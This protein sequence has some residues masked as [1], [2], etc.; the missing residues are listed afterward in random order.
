MFFDSTATVF[1]T[2]SG[3]KW[4]KELLLIREKYFEDS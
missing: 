3:I 4:Q 1:Q 2:E